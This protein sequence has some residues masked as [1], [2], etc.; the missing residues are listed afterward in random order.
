[1]NYKQYRDHLLLLYINMIEFSLLLSNKT[2]ID[3]FFVQ[4]TYKITKF[5]VKFRVML[6]AGMNK[7]VDIC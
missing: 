5:G 4:T 2:S 3:Q 1:M 6:G 7:G